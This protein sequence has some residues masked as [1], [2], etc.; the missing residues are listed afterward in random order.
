M[1]IEG[2]N[3]ELIDVDHN[4][5]SEF[6]FQLSDYSRQDSSTTHIRTIAMINE[7]EKGNKL[8]PNVQFRKALMVAARNIVVVHRCIFVL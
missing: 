7:L 3:I 5:Q 8:N 1:S 6:Y 4:A 2:C